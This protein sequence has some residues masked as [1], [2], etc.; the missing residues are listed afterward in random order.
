MS[1]I[2]GTIVS[3]QGNC[4]LSSFYAFSGFEDS[5]DDHESHVCSFP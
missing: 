1:G 4:F 3:M 5:T 2:D